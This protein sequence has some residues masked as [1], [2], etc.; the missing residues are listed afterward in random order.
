MLHDHTGTARNDRPNVSGDLHL[1]CVVE[2]EDML[3]S[4]DGSAVTFE[5]FA[6]TDATTVTTDGDAIVTKLITENTPTE[7]PDGTQLFCIPLPIDTFKAYLELLVTIATQELAT[8]K[9]TA[10]IGPPIQQGGEHGAL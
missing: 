9:I 8:G 2:D 5:L 6:D 1:N 3:A 4:V 7:H 10:W